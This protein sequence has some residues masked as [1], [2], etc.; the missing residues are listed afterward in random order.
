MANN[1]IVKE[2]TGIGHM[3]MGNNPAGFELQ[4]QK[5]PAGVNNVS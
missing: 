2:S 3:E 5:R 4:S 1:C